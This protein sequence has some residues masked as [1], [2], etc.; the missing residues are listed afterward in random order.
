MCHVP[1]RIVRVTALKRKL[2]FACKVLRDSAQEIIQSRRTGEVNILLIELQHR[3]CRVLHTADIGAGDDH[4]VRFKIRV[5]LVIAVIVIVVIVDGLDLLSRGGAD[6]DGVA[7]PLHIGQLII[8]QQVERFF[9]R[10]RPDNRRRFAPFNDGAGIK[11]LL[12]ALLT[13]LG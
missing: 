6:D 9:F 3:H 7:R 2:R 12:I 13:I 11:D 4:L 1:A 5:I 8:E 10:I